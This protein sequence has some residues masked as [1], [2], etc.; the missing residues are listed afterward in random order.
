MVQSRTARCAFQRTYLTARIAA[1]GLNITYFIAHAPIPNGGHPSWR[2]ASVVP[3]G[4]ISH[5]RC[6]RFRTQRLT[7]A[8]LCRGSRVVPERP[9]AEAWKEKSLESL[10]VRLQ[11]SRAALPASAVPQQSASPRR[12]PS[13]SSSAAGRRRSTLLWPTL[14]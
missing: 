7:P 4:S 11:S 9:E 12:A 2:L 14:G 10:R 3:A 13:S 1:R 8:D 5:H 6:A